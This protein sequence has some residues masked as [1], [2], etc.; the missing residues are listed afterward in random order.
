MENNKNLEAYVKPEMDVIDI[1]K[2]DVIAT[3]GDGIIGMSVTWEDANGN[4]YTNSI[5]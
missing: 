5:P 3:S 1:E 2:D 4:T